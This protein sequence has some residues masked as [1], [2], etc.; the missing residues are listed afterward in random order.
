[1][2]VKKKSW[3]ARLTENVRKLL[4]VLIVVFFVSLTL[5]HPDVAE[6]VAELFNTTAEKVM[7]AGRH[8]YSIAFALV[9]VVVGVF[10]LSAVPFIGVGLALVGVAILAYEAFSIF[11]NPLSGSI[12][13]KG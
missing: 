9:A 1:M 12:T 13:G 4:S 2:A 8:I 10:V 6:K 11:G 7:N 3:T 5:T